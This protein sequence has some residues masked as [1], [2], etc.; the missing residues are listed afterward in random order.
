MLLHNFN[1]FHFADFN[2]EDEMQ[3]LSMSTDFLV[4]LSDG[5]FSKVKSYHLFMTKI[6]FPHL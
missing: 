4:E 1:Y 6:T 2:S 5:F 3:Q